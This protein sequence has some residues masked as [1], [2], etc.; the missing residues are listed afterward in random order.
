MRSNTKKDQEVIEITSVLCTKSAFLNFRGYLEEGKRILKDAIKACEKIGELRHK[1]VFLGSIG[2]AYELQGNKQK[3][4]HFYNL[5]LEISKEPQVNN[6]SD[7][8]RWHHHLGMIYLTNDIDTATEYLETSLKDYT[9]AGDDWRIGFGIGYLGH[10]YS[11]TGDANRAI[12][13]YQQALEKVQN[14]KNQEGIFLYFI[15]V[16]H[17]YLGN[18]IKA[19]D[20]IKQSIEVFEKTGNDRFANRARSDLG[21][22]H[23]TLGEMELAEQ[24]FQE[25][26]EQSRDPLTRVRATANMALRHRYVGDLQTAEEIFLEALEGYR[27]LFD[28]RGE[29]DVLANLGVTYRYMG[30]NEKAIEVHE[31]AFCTPYRN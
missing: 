21:L 13:A 18:L 15:G 30:L 1:G 27:G 8:A 16:S 6:S 22:S 5:A 14:D 4:I 19:V 12:E 28:K 7:R 2:I 9:E 17:R 26:F 11:A 3:A 24:Y 31:E 20:F 10:V 23:Y 29:A 25:V